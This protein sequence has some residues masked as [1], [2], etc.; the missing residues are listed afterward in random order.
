MSNL[1]VVVALEESGA[2]LQKDLAELAH[3]E[4]PTMAEMLTRMQRDGMISRE[5]HPEDK[6]ASLISLTRKASGRLPKA[7]EALWQGE[8][9]ATAGLSER[10]R[11][12]LLELLQRVVKNLEGE[13]SD[14]T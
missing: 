11:A 9:E 1:P 12:L 14:L 13:F 10:E 8:Q 4:Q 3:V 5:P 6:R 7:K 2:L